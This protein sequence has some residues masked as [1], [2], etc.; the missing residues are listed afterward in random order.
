[1]DR[2]YHSFYLRT[3]PILIT[4]IKSQ[5]YIF[6]ISDTFFSGKEVEYPNFVKITNLDA[7]Q[8]KYHFIE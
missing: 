3:I 1:M 6:N 7:Q 8:L 5:M 2:T 4:V